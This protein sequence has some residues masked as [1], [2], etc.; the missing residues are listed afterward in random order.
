MA[1]TSILPQP[2]EFRAYSSD[3]IPE[4]W[5]LYKPQIQKAIDRGSNYTLTQVFYG[6]CK[7][8]MQLWSYGETAL[9]TT[10]QVKDGKTHCLLLILGG[11][12]MSKWIQYLPIVEDWAR[13]EGAE[14]VRIY[15]RR[16]WAKVL[17]YD[18]DWVKLVKKL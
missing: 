18:I 17:G 2:E 8:E 7:K 13:D 9:V 4:I 15:G 5:D 14:E 11:K 16:A 1:S 3:Q 12:G 10:I 6:L